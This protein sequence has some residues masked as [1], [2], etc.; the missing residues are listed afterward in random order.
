MAG[1]SDPALPAPGMLRSIY[2]NGAN[3]AQDHFYHRCALLLLPGKRNCHV[4]CVEPARFNGI[5]RAW[6]QHDVTK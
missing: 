6:H 2:I 3:I 5:R 4:P 1:C